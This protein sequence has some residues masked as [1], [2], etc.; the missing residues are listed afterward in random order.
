MTSSNPNPLLKAPSPTMFTLWDSFNAGI[1]GG[2][3]HSVHNVSLLSILPFQLF[4][5]SLP[6]Y[7]HPNKLV[8]WVLLD[9][10]YFYIS[11]DIGYRRSSEFCLEYYHTTLFLHYGRVFL[12]G[13]QNW[14]TSWSNISKLFRYNI[15]HICHVLTKYGLGNSQILSNL[16]CRIFLGDGYFVLIFI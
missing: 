2:H 7:C 15:P 11:L 10:S 4:L 9:K 16:I 5:G 1:V 8:F 12:K 14:V 13:H 6:Y 3:K